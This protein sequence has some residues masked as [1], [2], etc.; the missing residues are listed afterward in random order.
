M[1]GGI[2]DAQ[3][4]NSSQTSGMR[5]MPESTL[6]GSSIKQIRNK[7][8][9]KLSLQQKRSPEMQ[10][11]RGRPPQGCTHR[12]PQEEQG[13]HQQKGFCQNSSQPKYIVLI[14][15]YRWYS[16]PGTIIDPHSIYSILGIIYSLSRYPNTLWS[17]YNYMGSAILK[18]LRYNPCQA[19]Q[20]SK[21]A[22]LQLHCYCTI[23]SVK[24]I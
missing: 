5:T 18:R 4:V 8:S 20:V 6:L 19:C 1:D 15:I 24:E 23:K 7:P 9:V 11:R 22:S 17:L 12:R 14:G 10:A 2:Q 3:A 13:Q 16:S 21:Q